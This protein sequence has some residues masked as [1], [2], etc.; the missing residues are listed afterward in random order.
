MGPHKHQN[1]GILTIRNDK[2]KVI[3]CLLYQAILLFLDNTYFF[4]F[5]NQNC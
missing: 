5:S 4:I 1:Q 3:V 2:K